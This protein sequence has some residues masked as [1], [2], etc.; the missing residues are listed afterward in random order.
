MAGEIDLNKKEKEDEKVED[1][2]EEIVEERGIEEIPEEEFT[3]K[4]ERS[5]LRMARKED[6][7][8]D[9]TLR[10][11]PH[12][13]RYIL[14]F[15]MKVG[16]VPEF[17]E[18]LSRDAYYIDTPN[19]IYPVGDPIFV[20]I[21][22]TETEK[23]RYFAIEPTLSDEEREKYNKILDIMLRKSSLEPAYES[24]E[25]FERTVEKLLNDTVVF[26]ETGE[27]EIRGD[28]VPLTKYQYSRIRYNIR[29][30]IIENGHLEPL[31][32]DTYI[33]D[34]H[35]ISTNNIVIYHKIFGMLETNIK[36]KTPIELDD[37]L[38]SM[39]ERIGRPVSE[40]RP[41]VDATLLD[42]SRINIIYSDDVSIKGPSFTIRKFS[43]N[44]LTITQ[45]V[46]WNTMSPRI[47]AYLWLCLENDMSVF[48]CG[49][50]AS[51]KTTTLNAL[52]AFINFDKKIYT[53][54][55]T[56][57][58]QAPHPTWQR[59][60]TRESGPEG[61]RVYMFDLLKAALRSRPDY[62]IV[63]EVRGVEGAIAFQ[64]IQ[65][66]HP[67]MT[68]FHASSIKK[69]IQRFTGDPINVPVRFMDNL[70]VAV[71]QQAM[72]IKGKL[73]RRI[74]SVE[75]ILGYSSEVGGVMTQP[76]FGWDPITDTHFFRGMNN[77]YILENK[78]ADKLGF[79]D[80]RKIYDELDTRTRVIEKM[81][82]RNI[83]EY[84]QVNNVMKAYHRFG[85]AGL[86]FSVK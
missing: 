50:T 55:D 82:E 7:L 79:D 13:E 23:K 61:G 48:V 22:G 69:M 83:L 80:R 60:V 51:G 12:L 68:T 53:A 38:W 21:Y 86:P 75:E 3:F 84:E 47:A 6:E 4:V 49:E 27:G 28:K 8:F 34:I 62:I 2:A 65:T 64:A 39:S 73:Y 1:R 11:N 71:F 44:P 70:N 19:I 56:P 24:K 31:I 5:K 77:S 20:H 76:V 58:V 25:E 9:E 45:L 66:G 10:N 30:N 41:I 54:E 40:S 32:R 29:R 59:L 63:G 72:Y 74:T 46:R 67:V 33:E 14:K 57:E 43:K 16:E 85:Y 81:V 52:L 18:I 26:S 42:G 37:F 36:F 78:I 17:V 15:E 35:C